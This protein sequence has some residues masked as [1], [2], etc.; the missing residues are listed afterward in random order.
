M[1]IKNYFQTQ[2]TEIKND[3]ALRIFGVFMGMGHVY[4][5]MN[6][7]AKKQ[8]M[9]LAKTGEPLCWPFFEDCF[10]YR[11]FNSVEMKG[12]FVLFGICALIGALLFIPKRYCT[13]AYW[14]QIG[15]NIFK[16]LIYIQDFRM[17]MNQHYILYFISFV[18]LFMPNKRN[19]IRYL[20]T[21]I[22]FGAGLLKYNAE[23]ISGQALNG[24]PL[25]ISGGWIPVSC[26][27]V[28]VL[29]SCIVFGT[30]AKNKYIFWAAVFQLYLFHIISWPLVGFFYPLLMFSLLMVF[31]LARFI[32]NTTDPPSLI[33]SFLQGKQHVST[34]ILTGIF[35]CLQFIPMIMPGDAKLTRE[36][37]LFALHMFDALVYCNGDLTLKFKDGGTEKI[38][39]PM[40]ETTRIK[41]D[42]VVNFSRARRYCWQHEDD[43]NFSDLDFYYEARRSREK[44]MRPLVDVKDF[45]SQNLNYN[46]LRPNAWIKKY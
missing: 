43:P 4:S 8:Y 20:L 14:W 25:F 23:W 41:C 12:I 28:I 15:I 27:Y 31:P 26:L 39:I 13:L 40:N 1:C 10:K 45:C 11:F 46:M 36:G 21:L 30:L 16:T 9:N 32:K 3:T 18:F 29:E 44:E 5:V 7:M 37:R 38:K 19:S 42:P 6:W 2:I 17:R 24:E 35:L 33:T 22:Y 34:Y